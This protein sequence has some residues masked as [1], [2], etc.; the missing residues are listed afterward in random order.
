MET[1]FVKFN[2]IIGNSYTLQISE[3]QMIMQ[4]KHKK[5]ELILLDGSIIDIDIDTYQL[6]DSALDAKKLLI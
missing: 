3:I 4:N 2:D 6:I 1:I 5:I